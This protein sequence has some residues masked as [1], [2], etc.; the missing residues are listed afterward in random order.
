MNKGMMWVLVVVALVVGVGIG[1]FAERQR[2][3]D[4]LEA[5][6]LTMQKHVDDSMMQ[7][8]GEEQSE[9]SMQQSSVVM[10]AKSAKLGAYVTGAN[11]MAL[12]TYDKDGN[13]LSNC[14]G[15]CAKKWPPYT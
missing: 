2:A 12:Y 6:K 8:K 14:T 1:F 7:Q 10:M 9:T 4:K 15:E 11:G 13:D 3:T 5:A